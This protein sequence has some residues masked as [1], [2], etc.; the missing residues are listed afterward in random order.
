MCFTSLWNW[1]FQPLPLFQNPLRDISSS[2]Q[3]FQH[4]KRKWDQKI[5]ILTK[6]LSSQNTPCPFC[7]SPVPQGYPFAATSKSPLSCA[8]CPQTKHIPSQPDLDFLFPVNY[9]CVSLLLRHISPQHSHLIFNLPKSGFPQ[10]FA[11]IENALIEGLDHLLWLPSS[12]HCFRF[13]ASWWFHCTN[14]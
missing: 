8:L 6:I 5:R 10:E 4:H 7:H 12:I 14:S 3:S 1:F 9:H 13:P 11:E 2:Q